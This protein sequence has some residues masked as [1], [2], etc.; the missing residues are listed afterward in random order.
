[1]SSEVS[2]APAIEQSATSPA[3]TSTTGSGSSDGGAGATDGEAE[4]DAL[5]DAAPDALADGSTDGD[6][7]AR[8]VEHPTAVD[9]T[10]AAARKRILTAASSPLARHLMG[11]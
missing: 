4:A 6:S 7:E 2:A 5:A 9:A 11:S 10:S 8:G 1:M 3:A